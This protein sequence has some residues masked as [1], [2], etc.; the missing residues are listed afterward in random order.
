MAEILIYAREDCP[1]CLKAKAL[2]K[3]K[4]QEFSEIDV[5]RDPERL[6]EM[7]ARSRGRKT[8]PEI[9]INGELIGGYNELATLSQQGRLDEILGLKREERERKAKPVI[10]GSGP[11]GLTAA[12]YTARAALQPILVAGKDLGGQLFTTTQVENYPGFPDGVQ[13]PELMERMLEQA[14]RFGME[15]IP[16]EAEGVD[17]SCRPFTVRLSNNTTIL[18]E[19]LIIA[20]GASPRELGVKGER[21]LRGSGVSTCATCDGPFFHDRYVLVVGGGDSA[22]EEALFV[23]KFAHRVSVVHRRDRLRASKVMQEKA[24]RHE[25]I[26]FLWHTEVR[27][28]HG[29]REKGVTGVRLIN[30]KTREEHDVECQGVFIAIGHEPNTALFRGQIETD[31]KGF[32]VSR[33]FPKTSVPGVFVAGDVYDFQFKQ[34]VTAAGDGCKAA[35]AAERFLEEIHD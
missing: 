5:T 20:T 22:M 21:E 1:Y 7:L 16:A 32:I 6:Q 12:L 19:A 9:F 23:S 28:I 26:D 24:F 3:E 34:A 29:D 13:G 33:E 11:A 30:H 25:K 4:G 8:V 27:E 14:L 2:L 10:L 35:L 17:L 31:E 15:C 18:A